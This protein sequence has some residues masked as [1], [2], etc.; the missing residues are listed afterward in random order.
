MADYPNRVYVQGS[1]ID[2]PRSP[3]ITRHTTATAEQIL[4]MRPGY[5]IALLIHMKGMQNATPCSHCRAAYTGKNPF[6]HFVGC[7]SLYSFQGGACS[8]CVW[9]RS[10]SYCSH[11]DKS[12]PHTNMPYDELVRLGLYTN[13]SNQVPRSATMPSGQFGSELR[14]RLALPAS[15]STPPAGNPS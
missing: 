7:V 11:H 4:S 3:V 5:I 1:I 8:N 10:A 15:R 14:R 9:P 2:H 12:G 13:N 6:P